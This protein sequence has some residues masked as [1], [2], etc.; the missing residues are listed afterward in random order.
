[1]PGDPVLSCPSWVISY[2]VPRQDTAYYALPRQL[3]R[4]VLSNARWS[5]TIL[6][7]T[8]CSHTIA[9]HASRSCTLLSPASDRVTP[10]Q[11]TLI[12]PCQ[13]I[14]YCPVPCQETLICCPM[15][16]DPKL[17][18]CLS[19]PQI[20]A[21]V[22]VAVNVAAAAPNSYKNFLANFRSCWAILAHPALF[23]ISSR[24]QKSEK[25]DDRT[26][27]PAIIPETEAGLEYFSRIS[28]YCLVTQRK[29]EN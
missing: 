12:C 9:S 26:T 16:G 28:L 2:S 5:R 19:Q 21:V 1:M 24:V 7:H 3:I 20:S 6:S 18:L 11:K 13:V 27:V 23:W 14:P 22:Y 15:P 4:T 25:R 17:F 29:K 10:C 8:R